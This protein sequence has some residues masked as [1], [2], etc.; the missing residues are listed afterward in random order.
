MMFLYSC[1]RLYEI[2]HRRMEN[3][4]DWFKKLSHVDY[5]KLSSMRIVKSSSRFFPYHGKVEE[6]VAGEPKYC[7][8]Q[9]GNVITSIP[10]DEPE[11]FLSYKGEKLLEDIDKALNR[12]KL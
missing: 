11:L 1:G 10:N 4:K 5:K 2:P 3:S 8:L 6:S 7:Y 12:S 9:R